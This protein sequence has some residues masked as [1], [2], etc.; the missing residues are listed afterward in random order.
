MPVLRQPFQRAWDWK[1]DFGQA[2]WAEG[3]QPNSEDKTCL[4]LRPAEP[5]QLPQ[6]HRQPQ[7]VGPSRKDDKQRLCRRVLLRKLQRKR[8]NPEQL[9]PADIADQR[10][11]FCAAGGLR[12]QG[13]QKGQPRHDLRQVLRDL[14]Q[15]RTAGEDGREESLQQLRY[16]QRL[17]Q[18]QRQKSRGFLEL[19]IQRNWVLILRIP[20]GRTPWRKTLTIM[21]KNIIYF[22]CKYFWVII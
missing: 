2:H 10:R 19:R 13:Q 11:F 21:M 22:L 6:V 3:R 1:E 16:G 18:Q 20:P 14:R 12:G 7:R 4:C 9:F 15:R 8:G 5:Y 17:L